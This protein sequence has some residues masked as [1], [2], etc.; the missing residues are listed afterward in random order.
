M[1]GLY[2]SKPVGFLLITVLKTCKHQSG[3]LQMFFKIAVLEILQIAQGNICV[4]VFFN[5]VTVLQVGNFLKKRLQNKCFP[6]KF[7][8]FLRTSFLQNTSG[9]CLITASF[10]SILSFSFLELLFVLL[11][12]GSIL[13]AST[14]TNP[15]KHLAV[16]KKPYSSNAVLGII[17]F[18]S[19]LKMLKT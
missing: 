8:K 19:I 5:K 6:M 16:Y 18:E 1:P 9:D 10:L 7:V 2:L 11:D 3:Y 15:C 4:G 12:D 17:Q 13:K 14:K